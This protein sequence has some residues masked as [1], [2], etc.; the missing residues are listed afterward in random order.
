MSDQSGQRQVVIVGGGFAGLFAARALRRS[1]SVTLI[2]RPSTMCS[3]RCSTSARRASCPRKIGTPLRDLLKRHKNIDCV[4]AE[5]VDFDVEG[6]RVI[7]R[8]VGGNLLEYGY[9]ELIV[10]AGVRQSFRPR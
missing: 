4:M 8:R 10:A 9:D 5:V 7:A 2:D 6:R 1:V 3:R